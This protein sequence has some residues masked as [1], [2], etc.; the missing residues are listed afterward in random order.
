LANVSLAKNCANL[1]LKTKLDNLKKETQSK[2]KNPLFEMTS[3]FLNN[4]I[5]I[6]V[7]KSLNSFD[8][9]FNGQMIRE[10]QAQASYENYIIENIEKPSRSTMKNGENSS[11]NESSKSMQ[12]S[13]EEKKI[14]KRRKQMIQMDLH[15]I[16]C[17]LFSI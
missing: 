9:L 11:N 8:Y 4:I 13:P 12:K 6:L 15:N 16:F 17:K 14:V 2:E 1:I 10:E 3:I 7:E 5:S